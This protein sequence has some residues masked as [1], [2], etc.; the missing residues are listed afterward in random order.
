MSSIKVVC[1]W[2]TRLIA[3]SSTNRFRVAYLGR[4]PEGLRDGVAPVSEERF[5]NVG[6]GTSARQSGSSFVRRGWQGA[7]A[8]LFESALSVVIPCKASLVSFKLLSSRSFNIFPLI[9]NYT[10]YCW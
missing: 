8:D 5:G 7:L 3:F 4:G 6:H 2:M 9:S 10:L 1:C